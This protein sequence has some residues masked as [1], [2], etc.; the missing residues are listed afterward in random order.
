MANLL[1]NADRYGGGAD[2][3]A[4]RR[5]GGRARVEVDDAGPGVPVALREEVFERFARGAAAGRRGVDGGSGL[6][7]ALVAAAAV[8]LACAG[9]GVDTQR[10]CPSGWTR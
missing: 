1:D 5:G 7:L 6:M 4:V 3:V 8:A 9:C 2:R 10:P